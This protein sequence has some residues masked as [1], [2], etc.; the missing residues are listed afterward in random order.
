[1]KKAG[2]ARRILTGFLLSFFALCYI[3]SQANNSQKETQPLEQQETQASASTLQSQEE[4]TP[5]LSEAE[6]APQP[7]I[8]SPEP[9]AFSI[10]SYSGQPSQAV[11]NNV[12]YFS[13]A[14][15][16]TEKFE[17]YGELDDK[18]RVTGCFANVCKELMPTTKRESVTSVYPTGWVQKQYKGI[19]SGWLYNRCHLIG[20]QL[21]AQ[22]AN[23]R[24]LLTGTA[25]FNTS[26]MLPYEDKVANY[27]KATGNHVLYRA[28]PWFEGNELLCRGLQIEAY[29]VEDA[30]K[31]ISFN[32]FVFNVQPGVSINYAT[33][34]SWQD[35]PAP[36]KT[37]DTPKAETTSKP[38]PA[39]PEKS[40]SFILNTNTKKAHLPG[41]SAIKTM[42]ESN[43]QSFSGTPQQLIDKGYSPCKKCHPW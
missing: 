17:V 20:Y 24:N 14:S 6:E 42:K 18:G 35:T 28:T 12:P 38:S 5:V 23:P 40:Q 32:V 2:S 26:G 27:V 29:S 31:G 39:A 8:T 16:T 22:N 37:E 25:Y 9:A 3:G 43:K 13:E 7:E 30:G 21:T 19:D 34:E 15:K 1:M 10:P 4:S 33:G 41:C 36:T 11:N